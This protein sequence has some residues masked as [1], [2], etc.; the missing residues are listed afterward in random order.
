MTFEWLS[1][2][3]IFL[4]KQIIHNMRRINYLM[5]KFAIFQAIISLIVCYYSIYAT[6]F[7][8]LLS[9]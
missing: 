3:Q 6:E 4:L 1:E 5:T 2:I 7:Q 9:R 8:Q